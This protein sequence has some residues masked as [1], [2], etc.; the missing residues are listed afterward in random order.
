MICDLWWR[1]WCFY[2]YKSF[3]QLL[4]K[5]RC[6]IIVITHFR[7]SSSSP[8]ITRN[9]RCHYHPTIQQVVF[10]RFHLLRCRFSQKLWVKWDPSLMPLMMWKHSDML[11]L[12]ILD[13]GFHKGKCLLLNLFLTAM[14]Y[15]DNGSSDFWAYH[16][17]I[18]R[19]SIINAVLTL[20]LF[21]AVAYYR[22]I[23]V[24][25]IMSIS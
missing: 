2:N 3:N 13:L 10:Q 1:M 5:W 22:I 23:S 20:L 9:C 8:L 17:T 12:L 25:L 24:N 4:L 15:T 7:I 21:N 11:L 14:I 16:I 6:E 19:F 18:L